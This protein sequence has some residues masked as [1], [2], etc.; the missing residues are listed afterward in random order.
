M[1]L[2]SPHSEVCAEWFGRLTGAQRDRQHQG[3][4]FFD[5]LLDGRTFDR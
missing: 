1:R 3:P 4:F 5:S 2:G